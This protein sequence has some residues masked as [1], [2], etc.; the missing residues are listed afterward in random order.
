M[1]SVWQSRSK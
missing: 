1:S